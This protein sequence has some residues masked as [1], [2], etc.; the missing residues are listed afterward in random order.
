M[1]SMRDASD[2]RRVLERLLDDVLALERVDT[3]TINDVKPVFQAMPGLRATITEELKAAQQQEA[4]T[5]FGG[6]R[7]EGPDV[8]RDWRL[9]GSL[10]GPAVGWCPQHV[11]AAAPGEPVSE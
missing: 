3:P 11:P 9:G 5:D 10:P 6:E 2:R 4:A 1:A 7:A 8:Y